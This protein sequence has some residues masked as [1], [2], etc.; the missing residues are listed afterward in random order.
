MKLRRHCDEWALRTMC[1]V[2]HTSTLPR[3]VWRA[4]CSLRSASE[5][6]R[7]VDCGA[8]ILVASQTR[9]VIGLCPRSRSCCFPKARRFIGCSRSFDDRCRSAEFVRKGQ[10]E[11]CASDQC[12]PPVQRN[13][14]DG[15]ENEA[16]ENCPKQSAKWTSAPAKKIVSQEQAPSRSRPIPIKANN[17]IT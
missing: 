5:G 13:G 10:P 12:E 17:A 3:T 4:R 15:D 16:I 2:A 8:T 1:Y 9:A 11:P 7:P 6:R 14:I